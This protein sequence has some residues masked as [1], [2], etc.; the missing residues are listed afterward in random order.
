[1]YQTIPMR[2]YIVISM[3]RVRIA[4]KL[5][6]DLTILPVEE[7]YP[8]SKKKRGGEGLMMQKCFELF[9]MINDSFNRFCACIDTVL[10]P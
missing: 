9:V 10:N 4:H 3:N 8:R 2:V 6:N 5:Q 7:T 1:M